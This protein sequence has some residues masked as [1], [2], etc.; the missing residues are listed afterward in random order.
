MNRVRVI[1]RWVHFLSEVEISIS[2]HAQY[3]PFHV[4]HSRF[5][6]KLLNRYSQILF[7]FTYVIEA[8]IWWILVKADSKNIE[9]FDFNR[10]FTENTRK[11]T[12]LRDDF[13]PHTKPPKHHPVGIDFFPYEDYAEYYIYHKFQPGPRRDW[14][15]VDPN[16][17]QKMSF[18][19]NIHYSYLTTGV[20]PTRNFEHK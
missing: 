7:I 19:I 14:Y 20:R 17:W 3:E 8:R 18:L 15:F 6:I 9:P 12:F 16:I 10:D 2:H 1:F 5:P 11:C 13:E 4:S